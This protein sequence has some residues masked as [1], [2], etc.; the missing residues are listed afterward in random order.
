MRLSGSKKKKKEKK[1][2]N[3]FQE[4]CGLEILGD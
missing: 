1:K 3:F 4:I 2:Y